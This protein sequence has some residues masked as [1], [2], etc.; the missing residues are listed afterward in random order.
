ML[1]VCRVLESLRE[2][3]GVWE[4]TRLFVCPRLIV[5]DTQIQILWIYI[6]EG[7]VCAQLRSIYLAEHDSGF[8]N[9]E[10]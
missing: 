3:D 6:N 4:M 10:G 8:N 1:D 2:F 7:R 5:D 9:T